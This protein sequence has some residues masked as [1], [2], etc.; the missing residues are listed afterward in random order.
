MFCN[1]HILRSFSEIWGV[2]KCNLHLFVFV[3]YIFWVVYAQ[4]YATINCTVRLKWFYI[5]LIS[6]VSANAKGVGMI[7][8]VP[9]TLLRNSYDSKLFTSDHTS[10]ESVTPYPL[11][12]LLRRITGRIGLQRI[13][14][15]SKIKNQRKKGMLVENVK[16]YLRRQGILEVYSTVS[17]TIDNSKIQCFWRS[18]TMVSAI[19]LL[20]S[21]RRSPKKKTFCIF[22]VIWTS[23][24]P[25]WPNYNISPTWIFLVIQLQHTFQLQHHGAHNFPNLSALT[26]TWP[27]QPWNPTVKCRGVVLVR[28]K[29]RQ[30]KS[31]VI[32]VRI[33]IR[34]V[35]MHA[36]SMVE[37][38]TST[39][40][41]LVFRCSLNPSGNSEAL[42]F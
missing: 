17:A 21:R 14:Q 29:K 40:T 1:L 4:H 11:W 12:H 16:K 41:K 2:Q 19:E 37:D 27:L 32:T 9:T 22:L 23:Y 34:P 10:S 20:W 28:Q 5:H 26:S 25:I 36:W 15:E 6:F 18:W 38:I 13:K 39:V 30:D 8:V 42:R 3:T 35:G 7:W 33:K 31:T 24:I